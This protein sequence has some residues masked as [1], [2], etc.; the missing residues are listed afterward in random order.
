MSV[1]VEEVDAIV[2]VD[3]PVL[4]NLQ[5]T[6]AYARM[7]EDFQQ[8][9]DTPNVSWCAF[10]AW[11]S[12][13]VGG[14]IRRRQTDRSWVLRLMRFVQPGRYRKLGAVAA[15][16][17]ADGNVAVFDHIGR[18][19]ADFH[20]A[21]AEADDGA[22]PRF[23]AALPVPEQPGPGAVDIEFTPAV[24]LADGFAYY[25]AARGETAAR[26][27]AQLVCAGNLCLAHVEQ[28][29]LQA[30]IAA[31]FSSILPPTLAEG[32]WAARSADRLVTEQILELRIADERFRPGQA[33]EALDDRRYPDDLIDLDLDL[34][35][36]FHAVLPDPA[37]L[38]APDADHWMSLKDRLRYIGALMRSR[39]QAVGLVGSMPFEPDQVQQI[40]DGIVPP[41]LAPPV[42]R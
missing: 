10:G 20:R 35:G 26:R 41:G 30:P 29:R 2:A 9:L 8:W 19:F 5:I 12:E 31:A 38:R 11:A 33:L 14:A 39:Q 22:V 37:A 18:A 28:V 24:G 15:K 6:V 13:G 40:D 34:F 32:R 23:M 1:T 16:A 17:F 4:R 25:L 42:G 3:C 27:Q 36:R 21:L 7:A